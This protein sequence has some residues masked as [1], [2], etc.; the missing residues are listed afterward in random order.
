MN[1]YMELPPF[2]YTNPLRLFGG[3]KK[4]SVD[5][6]FSFVLCLLVGC[7]GSVSLLLYAISKWKIPLTAPSYCSACFHRLL[8]FS[9]LFIFSFIQ[10]RAEAAY[11][12]DAVHLY[13]NALVR[14]LNS[15]E[16][17]RNGTA[18]INSLKGSSYLSAMG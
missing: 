4:V 6:D 15:D 16:N 1:H 12:Y 13:T 18:I 17:P 14:V 5:R 2:N 10:I 3:A 8:S 9:F 11:L 7:L